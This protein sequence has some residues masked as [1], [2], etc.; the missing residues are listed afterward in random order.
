MLLHA[1]RIQKARDEQ[2]LTIEGFSD[3]ALQPASYN[4]RLGDEAITSSHREKVD[5]SRRGLLVIPAGDFALVKTFERVVLSTRVAG[6]IGLR[7]HCV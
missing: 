1:D 6:H 4:F 5:P 2:L 3:E 7:S